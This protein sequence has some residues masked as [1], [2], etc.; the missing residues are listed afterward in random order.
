[1]PKLPLRYYCYVCGH[2][3]DLK[4]KVPDAPKIDRQQIRCSNCGDVTHLLVTGCPECKKSFR[5]FLTDLDF[6]TEITALAGVYV[7]LVSGIK[8]SLKNHIK[9]FN[10]PLPKKWSVNLTCECGHAYEAEIPL[11]QMK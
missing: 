5:Y 8:T 3:N 4:L 11:P 9:D 7:N 1:M 6:P 2:M 10:V